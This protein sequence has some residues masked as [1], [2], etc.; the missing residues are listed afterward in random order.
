MAFGDA[1]GAISLLTAADED[2]VLPLNG[3]EGQ[4]IEWVDSP[5]PLPDIEWTDSTFVPT[6]TLLVSVL[7]TLRR[8]PAKYHRHAIL[9]HP[10]PIVLDQ[11]VPA[12]LESQRC[13]PAAAEDPVAD[14]E[15]DEDQRQ[16]S[17][18]VV[19]EGAQGAQERCI[20]PA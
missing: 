6:L 20:F 11:Q 15:F 12:F 17:V 3:F 1:D 19:A 13:S 18:C 14:P 2:A 8:Q 16:C 4:P 9:Q 7:Y 5:D 10:A